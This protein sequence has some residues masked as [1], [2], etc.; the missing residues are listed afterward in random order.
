MN[1]VDTYN[2]QSI[3][4]SKETL[5]ENYKRCFRFGKNYITRKIRS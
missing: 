2:E 3:C 1:L 4:H 5:E